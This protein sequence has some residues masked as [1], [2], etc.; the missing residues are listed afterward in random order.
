MHLQVVVFNSNWFILL[1]D[2]GILVLINGPSLASL[3]KRHKSNDVGH[4]VNGT[5]T[6]QIKG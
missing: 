3:Q 5:Q 4:A 6:E 2:E 1:A